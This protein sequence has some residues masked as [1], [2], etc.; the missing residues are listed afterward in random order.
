MMD[1]EL[2]GNKCNS[3]CD[4]HEK[5]DFCGYYDLDKECEHHTCECE[6]SYRDQGCG[7][8]TCGCEYSY[9]N[10]CGCQGNCRR[11]CCDK[12][13]PWGPAVDKLIAK[14]L[15]EL[16][17]ELN[18]IQKDIKV[19]YALFLR[20]LKLFEQRGCVTPA[21]KIY[22]KRLACYIQLLAYASQ[23]IKSTLCCLT[24]ELK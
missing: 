10:N 20:L 23:E 21:T 5:E 11:H 6:D 4:Y 24:D 2:W 12:D 3:G 18:N 14:T 1:E 7:H 22:L 8:H 13:E 17:C 9:K 19:I 15:K 16:S